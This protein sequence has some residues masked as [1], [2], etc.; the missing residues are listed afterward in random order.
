MGTMAAALARLLGAQGQQIEDSVASMHR[1]VADRVFGALGPLGTPTRVVHDAISDGVH[2]A[3]RASLGGT[4]RLGGVLASG[5]PDEVLLASPRGRA[6]VGAVLGLIGDHVAEVEPDLDWPT[7]L[8]TASGR[9]VAT[10]GGSVAVPDAAELVVLLHGLC[11][12]E[13]AWSLGSTPERPS[14]PA[15]LAAPDRVVLQARMNSGRRP[16]DLGRDLAGLLEAAGPSG[17]IVLVG[18]SMGGLVARAALRTGAAAGHAW[19]GRC[20][21]VVTLGTPHLGAPLEKAVAALVRVGAP[22]PEVAAVTRWFE[23]RSAGIRDLRHGVDDDGAAPGVAVVAAPLPPHVRLHTVGAAL[24]RVGEVLGDGLV[25]RGSAHARSARRPVMARR[26][27]TLDIDG[28]H[29]D[30]LTDP[31]VT[32]HVARVVDASPA[33][34]RA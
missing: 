8:H 4:G 30:L 1:A 20:D 23:Q 3:V 12:T 31:R 7:T 19:V 29:F 16:A 26:G 2:G 9:A 13:L 11:E 18:H 33:L 32:A 15:L 21:T 14:L 27:A 10:V 28:S 17:R 22:V 34:E 24:P 5:V 25:R 6:L